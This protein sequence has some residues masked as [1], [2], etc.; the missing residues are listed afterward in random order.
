[1]R[2]PAMDST[3]SAHPPSPG[4]DAP[5]FSVVIPTLGRPELLSEAV[6]SVLAQTRTDWECIVVDDGAGAEL[7]TTDPRIRL[8][9]RPTSGGPAAARNTGIAAARGRYV[10]FLDDDDR[11]TPLRLEL[12]AE[13]LA[14][15]DIALCWSR[16]FDEDGPDP[17]VQGRRLQGDVSGCILD[18]TTPQLGAT[19]V[20]ADRLVPF[21][22]TYSAVEDVEWW[23]R[24]AANGT[25]ATI[26][27]LGYERRRH[28]GARTNGTDVTSRIRLSGH[29]VEHHAEY[30]Q[31]HPSA[32]AFRWARMG[33]LALLEGDWATS[34]RSYVRSLRIR[35]SRVA[36]RGLTRAVV[37]HP[38]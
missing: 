32:L 4:D 24:M 7:T 27:R 9:H 3:A 29:L 10:A 28:T 26:E 22:E 2:T 16:W 36:V 23:L 19:A 5:T 20:R 13:A 17:I 8:V 15:A 12:A 1:M 18:A 25:V 38:A 37:Q 6:A 30:F 14:R 11:F 31:A 35:P 34:R 33:H 21:D